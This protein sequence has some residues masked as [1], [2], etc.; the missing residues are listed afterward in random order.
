MCGERIIGAEPGLVDVGSSPRVRGTPVPR[1]ADLKQERF[2]P[3]CAG[4]A[5]LNPAK[6]MDVTVHPRVCGERQIEPEPLSYLR[7][8]SPRVRGTH[9]RH[10]IE[11]SR[12]RFIPA[13]AGNAH[14]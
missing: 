2:I 3:A 12:Y 11:L 10:L 1:Y 8:S 13:C 9:F 5:R 7:G 14:P 6:A 4:N